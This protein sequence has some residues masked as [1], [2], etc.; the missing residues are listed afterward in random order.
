MSSSK[1][2]TPLVASLRRSICARLRIPYR[3]QHPVEELNELLV[4]T[5]NLVIWKP[6]E[7]LRLMFLHVHCEQWAS[8]RFC[9]KKPSRNYLHSTILGLEL[10]RQEEREQTV[11]PMSPVLV[12]D[13]Y[14]LPHTDRSPAGRIERRSDSPPLKLS[15]RGP[16]WQ[17][18]R[19][20]ADWILILPSNKRDTIL[21]EEKAVG[22]G[23]LR[24]CG[25]FPRLP[26]PLRK[27]AGRLRRQRYICWRES[28]KHR[29]GADGYWMEASTTSSPLFRR[30]GYWWR[31][32]GLEGFSFFFPWL[33]VHVPFLSV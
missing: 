16:R 2:F 1:T 10:K 24:G 15:S 5:S 6:D 25:W 23:N 11:L 17:P 9:K 30:F 22:C 8:E 19:W 26:F 3:V 13:T 7:V 20:P 4:L 21:A 33:N 27:Y 31:I 14:A 18:E 29:F 28:A 32:L 12:C